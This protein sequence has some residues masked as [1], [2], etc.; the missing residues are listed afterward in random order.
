MPESLLQ[1]RHKIK[2]IIVPRRNSG[3]L[4]DPSMKFMLQQIGFNDVR[5][6]DELESIEVDGGYILGVPFF[7]EHGDLNIRTKSAYLVNLEKRSVLCVAD[8][9]NLEPLHR[10]DDYFLREFRQSH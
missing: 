9:N 7:G 10:I 1:L 5:E 8:S 4:A 2:T 3:S 6:L